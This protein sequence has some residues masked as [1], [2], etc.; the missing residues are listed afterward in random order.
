MSR[1]VSIKLSNL[2]KFQELFNEILKSEPTE[3]DGVSFETSKLREFKDKAREMAMIAA[4]EKAIAMTHAI[5]QTVG[6]AIKI[7]E[8]SNE[9]SYLSTSSA[10]MSNTITTRSEPTTHLTSQS[11]ASFSPGTVKVEATVTVI[12]KL[13]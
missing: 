3:V 8:A 12:F 11:L 9:S 2:V 13:D 10:M 6:K 1:T 4:K 5:G 7:T